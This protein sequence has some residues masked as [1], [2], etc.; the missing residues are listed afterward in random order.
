[1]KIHNS[2]E[3][4][5]Y[6]ASA[7]AGK[8]FTL[9]KEYLGLAL[10]HKDAFKHILAITFT[11]KAAN[12]MK[13]RV[14]S[15]LREISKPEEYPDS[16]TNLYVRPW[17]KEQMRCNDTLLNV[18]ASETLSQI[19]HNYADL[20]ILTIDSFMQRILKT[21]A[22][23][24]DIPVGF[25]TETDTD[26]LYQSAMEMVIAQAGHDKAITK[27]VSDFQKFHID[28]DKSWD[29]SR[30]L[31]QFFSGKITSDDNIKLLESL[32][33]FSIKDFQDISKACSAAEKVIENS[34]KAEA[35]KFMQ[36]CKENNLTLEDFYH[37]K[38]SIAS[39]IEKIVNGRMVFIDTN[40]RFDA[41]L[42][43]TLGKKNSPNS[44]KEI[45]DSY[46]NTFIDILVKLKTL[47]EELKPRYL[48]IQSMKT[49]LYPLSLQN[50]V[51][52]IVNDI[53]IDNRTVYISDFD[54]HIG[55]VIQNEAIPFIYERVGEWYN[56]IM[57]D[58]FQDTSLMQWHNL[59]P[60]V[61]NALSAGNKNMIVGDAKQA[62][63]RWRGGNAKQF[64]DLPTLPQEFDSP[65][66]KERELTIK[67][68]Y[69]ESQLEHNYRSKR[70]IIEF[71]NWFFGEAIHY[72]PESQRHIY[73]NHSQK[74]NENNIGG[75]IDI[76]F[77]D[78]GRK[79]EEFFLQ[80]K[81][82]LDDIL[83]SG[84]E[85]RDIAILVR[86]NAFAS[87]IASALTESNI[88]VITAESLLLAGSRKVQFLVSLI[89]CSIQPEN[90][91]DAM[92]VLQYLGQL[93][94][95][96]NPEIEYSGL[97]FKNAS[98]N[99]VWRCLRSYY[100]EMEPAPEK[101]PL[102]ELAEHLIAT[103]IPNNQRDAYL[104]HFLNEI[105]NF[106]KADSN[107]YNFFEYWSHRSTKA[108]LEVS[109]GIN[110]VRIS[111]IHKSKGLEYPVVLLPIPD[112]RFRRSNDKISCKVPTEISDISGEMEYLYFD[113]KKE[114]LDTPLAE[115]YNTEQELSM[116]DNVNMLY[117]AMTRASKRLS[118]LCK[119]TNAKENSSAKDFTGNMGDLITKVCCSHKDF[120]SEK[121]ALLINPNHVII[122]TGEKNDN[123]RIIDTKNQMECNMWRNVVTLS[124]PAVRLTE[125]QERSA[126]DT[127]L[128]IHSILSQI[129]TKDDIPSAIDNETKK[130]NI[131]IEEKHSISDQIVKIVTNAELERYYSNEGDVL[132]E[133]EI[134]TP[135]ISAYRPDR[136]VLFDKNAIIIDYKTGEEK[137]RHK[138]QISEYGVLLSEMGY[139][140]EKKILIYIKQD[141]SLEVVYV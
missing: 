69:R 44:K 108:S 20:A 46:L 40:T 50:E 47:K 117:V 123:S 32:K 56:H 34:V 66:T 82:F 80:V 76:R 60:L 55:K 6:K 75:V 30:A 11:N 131:S 23:D 114:L 92:A 130:G 121:K 31:L 138:K 68:H 35:E 120:D 17:L 19:L 57:I 33:V 129:S 13:E 140:I 21:F 102:Y 86:A 49:N 12:E 133:R 26:A 85:Y 125:S 112:E 134:I 94:S 70:E 109:E 101:L 51:N 116:I 119:S 37:G 89:R 10:R 93:N 27:A 8:T 78:K 62:I 48:L 72:I 106:A 87:Q 95:E 61:E 139:E 132:N 29:I 65:F 110:A 128:L 45:I 43:G 81:T 97:Q 58:E 14:I 118:V 136:V 1:M 39:Q 83:H 91:I 115:I 67:N 141:L 98:R 71:N 22:S 53:K 52:K 36:I 24:L 73:D 15:N 3:L 104:R 9:V 105:F 124:S 137:N 99:P 135:E 59:L 18:K 28:S 127:G 100:P 42:E 63:Y 4:L 5:V 96:I 107:R 38:T 79:D 90:K 25:E 88:P 113:M 54:T 77:I 126:R 122:K 111:T 64:S 7:G 74:Y 103:I 16:A 84:F 2:G 41:A